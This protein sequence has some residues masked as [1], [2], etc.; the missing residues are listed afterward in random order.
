MTDD[1]PRRRRSEPERLWTDPREEDEHTRWLAPK[2]T[3]A[4]PRP[5]PEP[6]P[7]PPAPPRPVW[8]LVAIGVLIAV[9]LFGGGV[10][11]AS[12]LRDDDDASA[13]VAALP[14]APGGVAPDARS[15]AVREIFERVSPSVV[16][17]SARGGGGTAAGG[18]GFV[19]DRD[20]TVVTNAHVVA[21]SSQVQ[22]RFDDRRAAV[23]A[24]VL[25]SDASTDL[26]VLR[27][28]AS[29]TRGLDPPAL[30]DSNAVKVGDLAVAMG[31]PLGLGNTVTV[32][33]VSGVGRA[34]KAPNGF[35]ID[36]VIQTDAPI[37]PGNSGGPLLDAAGRVIGVNSQIA[38]AGGGGGNVGI[39]FAV[40]SNTVRQVVPRLRS[41]GAISRPY[42]G[43]SSIGS[44][45]GRGA[46]VAEVV[47]GGPAD[48]AGVRPGDV[49]ARVDGQTIEAPEDISAAI[50]DRRPGDEIE[51]EVR[52]AGAE[53]TL[54]VRLGT[55][56]EKAPGS[57]P[58]GP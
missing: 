10:L 20:G 25:G 13:P 51:L 5:R 44:T 53:E 34:I 37:N 12:L 17:V 36:K 39:G 46:L 16:R 54:Q 50:Q 41:G 11:G 14:A 3:V 23:D 43:V 6:A 1:E 27:V 9:V 29:H 32:G 47:A 2:P 28:D 52:R 33:I 49:V 56:P 30:A 18:T 57:T 26:A 31:Y 38:T 21:G 55:R 48:Q 35:S 8:P 24:E 7:A 45:V 40:P 22:V 15:R 58:L 4:A 19:V 42:L